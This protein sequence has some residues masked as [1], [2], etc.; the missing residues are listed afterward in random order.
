MFVEGALPGE[1][2]GFLPVK[3]KAKWETA[4]MTEMYRESSQRVKPA[5]PSFGICGG[6]AIQHLEP[7]SQV[8]IKQRV[9]EDN[10]KH[11]GKVKAETMLR[12]I[13][14]PTWGYRYRARI[15][16]RHVVKKGSVL[17]GFH[18]RK[19]HFITDMKSCEVLPRHVSDMLVPLRELIGSLSIVD[20]M[21][22]I[23]LAI[24]EGEGGMITAVVVLCASWHR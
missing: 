14:G 11:I 4:T 12:P 20:K 23:E 13:Y 2:V 22:Q 10:L 3:R 24:G 16:V 8:A 21:P 9:L 18:E 5:C 7:A 6:C 15:S 17:V 19:S 1:R